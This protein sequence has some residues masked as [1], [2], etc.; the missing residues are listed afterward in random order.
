MTIPD[1]AKKP[2]RS[3]ADGETGLDRQAAWSV[4]NLR[5]IVDRRLRLLVPHAQIAPQSLHT[6][7]CYS[8]LAPGKR[9]RPILTL[10]SS[11]HF[12]ATDLVALD[13]ACALEMVHAA[14][15]IIDDLPAMDN[16]ELRRGQPTAHRQFGEEIAILSGVALLNQAFSVLASA[17]RLSDQVRL[18]LVRVFT[19]A[20][21]STGLIGGQVI[22]LKERTANM[23]PNR[24]EKLNELK[25]AALFVAAL[26]AGAV[27]AGAQGS[28]IEAARTFATKLGLAFQIADDMLDDPAFAGLTGKDTGKDRSKP[29]VVSVVGRAQAR[30][31]LDQY[32]AEAREALAQMGAAESPLTAFFEASIAHMRS[33]Q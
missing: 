26:E 27:V 31:I 30:V 4:D 10:L 1:S 32:V 23:S 24:L 6:A 13:A 28:S 22:D 5:V 25:T 21:G 9:L 16:S 33:A 11:Y 15:L 3:A 17:Q 18:E 29:T 12:G 20:V 14:S 8:L 2:K 7:M 19:S